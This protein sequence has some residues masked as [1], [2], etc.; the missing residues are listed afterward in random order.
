MA[1]HCARPRQQSCAASEHI[2]IGLPVKA[3][4]EAPVDAVLRHQT[5]HKLRLRC[6]WRGEAARTAAKRAA[7]VVTAAACGGNDD[8]ERTLTLTP[9]TA[10]PARR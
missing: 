8:G 1:W 7:V 4:N 9:R 6:W 10:A 2:E 5:S 3:F